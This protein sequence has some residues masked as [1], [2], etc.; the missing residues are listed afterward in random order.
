MHQKPRRVVGLFIALALAFSAF[1]APVSYAAQAPQPI[2]WEDIGTYKQDGS[3]SPSSE[4][5]S[6]VDESSVLDESDIIYMILTDRFYDGDPTNNGTL[7]HEYRPGELKYTQGGDW[8]GL[9]SK[10]QYVKNLGVT[11]IWISPPSQNE[12]LSRDGSESGYHGYFTHDYYEPD[13]H[14]GTKQDLIDLVS[15]AHRLELKVILDIVPNHSA[16]YLEPFATNYSSDDYQPA[17]PFNDPS[18][19]HHNGNITDWNNQY[20]V[21]NYDLGGLDDLDQD[22]PQ[23]RAALFDVYKMWVEDTGANGVRVDAA[24][25]IPKDFLAELEDELGVP[26]FGEIFVGD[27]DYV[28]DYQNYEWGVLDFPLFFQAREVFANDSSFYTVKNIFDQDYKYNNVNHLVTFIDNHDRDR[29]LCLADDNFQKMRLAL[30]FLFTVRG[31]PDVY[32]GTEQNCYGGGR[33]TEWAGI[34][35]KENREVMPGFSE[36]GNMFKT[37]QRLAE[38]RKDYVC[39]QSGVQREM[40][41]EDNIFAYSRRDDASGQEIITIINNGT[42]NETRD[43]PIRA[44]SSLAVGTQLTNLLDTSVTKTITSGGVTGKQLSIYLPAK[45]AYVFTSDSVDAYTP[46]DKTVT[47]IRVHYDVGY[48]NTIYLRGDSYPL[49]WDEGR[50]MLNI[51]SDVWIYEIERIPAGATFEFKPLINDTAWSTGN[52]YVGTGGQ[53]IDIYPNF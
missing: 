52:N 11:A 49:W 32:Y 36:D 2:A 43:I 19:Y 15:E 16:D 34:A 51:A 46:P 29:F 38:I 14:Y 35:N 18:W 17:A 12:L 48:G 24:R 21:E 20:E 41:V 45:T 27:V 3:F 37:I 47:T 10:L 26:T 53:T 5:A 31:V 7:N 6:I 50:G 8:V 9:T 33:P 13:P 44:E 4:V 28:S 1:L 22:N 42:S 39:L 23:A 25:S 40:W 30:T